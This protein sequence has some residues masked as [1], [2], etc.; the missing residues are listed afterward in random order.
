[1]LSLLKRYLRPEV[2]I[3]DASDLREGPATLEGIALAPDEPILSPFRSKPC[4]AYTYQV[5]RVVEARQGTMP[6]LVKDAHKYMEFFVS[7]GE[8]RVK[9][10]PT[11]LGTGITPE[12]HKNY[13]AAASEKVFINEKVVSAGQKVGLEGMI[14]RK[15][16]QWVM[17]SKILHD[18]GEVEDAQKAPQR[19]D[20]RKRRKKNKK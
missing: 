13:Q 6:T 7:V 5:Y 8:E 16:G 17:R 11:N 1:M 14:V 20:R 18:L 12:E 3:S 15:D 9:V 2:H 19:G 4:V 10:V